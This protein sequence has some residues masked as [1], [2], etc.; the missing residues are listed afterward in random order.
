LELWLTIASRTSSENF[1]ASWSRIAPVG[2]SQRGWALMSSMTAQF[3]VP[4][5]EFTRRAVEIAKGLEPEFLVNH[6]YRTFYFGSE[7]LSLA[8]RSFDAEILF[9]TSILHDIALGTE[10]EDGTTPFHIRGAGFAAKR[11]C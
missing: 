4:E 2:S 11:R 6:S 1:S 8:R 10:L 9:V 5:S 3:V 7:L